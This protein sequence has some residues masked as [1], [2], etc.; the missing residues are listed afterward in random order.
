MPAWVAASV[1]GLL[2]AAG[3]SLSLA[4]TSAGAAGSAA[5]T[6]PV[7]QAPPGSARMRFVDGGWAIPDPDATP[8][9]ALTTDAA[10]VCAPG[11]ART[12]RNVPTSVKEQVYAEYGITSHVPYQYEID[13]DISLELG[14]SNDVSNLWPE[15][16]D[17]ARGNTKDELEDKLHALVC[18]GSLSL[19]DAQAAIRGDWTIAYRKYVG[20]LGGYRPNGAA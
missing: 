11:Y 4:T 14:G 19:T 10:T 18:N 20:P 7:D 17:K 3:G 9:A 12:V 15:P 8:G 16:N 13:H 2:L 6:H 1:T 5:V